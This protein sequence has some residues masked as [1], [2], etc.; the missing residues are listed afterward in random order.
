VGVVDHQLGAV[1]P[2]PIIRTDALHQVPNKVSSGCFRLTGP[3]E[4][5]TKPAEALLERSDQA[6]VGEAGLCLL[7][8]G[9]DRAQRRLLSDPVSYQPHLVARVPAVCDH[10]PAQPVAE[11]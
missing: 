5:T 11:A 10:Y 1:G 3:P 8:F 9:Q 4:L 7:C 6:V 2:R